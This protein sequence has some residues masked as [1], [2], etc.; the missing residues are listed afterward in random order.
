[1]FTV[2]PYYTWK[3]S[4]HVSIYSAMY[5]SNFLAFICSGYVVRRQYNFHGVTETSLTWIYRVA[6]VRRAAFESLMILNLVLLALWHSVSAHSD[7]L[8]S[9]Q[10]SIV[11][12]SVFGL[13][14]CVQ[15]PKC[16]LRIRG[17]V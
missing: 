17:A 5:L 9:A 2:I 8:R 1:M 6:W 7:L 15:G 11:F 14:L 3:E 12:C 16:S 4:V 13:S 10:L